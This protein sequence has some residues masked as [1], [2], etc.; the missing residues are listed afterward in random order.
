MTLAAD[1]IFI[2][3]VTLGAAVL[4]G[5]MRLFG[6]LLDIGRAGH[7]VNPWQTVQVPQWGGMFSDVVLRRKPK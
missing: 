4:C 2:A 6:R 5:V 7:R 3:A 1:I